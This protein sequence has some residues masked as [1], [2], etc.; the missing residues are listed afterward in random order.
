MTIIKNGHEE[1]I[2]VYNNKNM[3][4]YTKPKEHETTIEIE[5]K[6][7]TFNRDK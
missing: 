7:F 1:E 4:L 6:E 5:W 2:R 3:P